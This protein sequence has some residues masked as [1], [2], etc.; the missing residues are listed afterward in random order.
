M[1]VLKQL[2]A[3][4]YEKLIRANPRCGFD[5]FACEQ[6]TIVVR[7]IVAWRTIGGMR[8]HND[9]LTARIASDVEYFQLDATIG[10]N[11]AESVA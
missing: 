4:E 5:G 2:L 11:A 6:R 7:G 8:G 1:A 3:G 9:P 10:Q